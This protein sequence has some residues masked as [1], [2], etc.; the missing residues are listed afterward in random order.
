M[1]LV[2]SWRSATTGGSTTPSAARSRDQFSP[3]LQVIVFGGRHHDY[4]V[5]AGVQ[6]FQTPM[7]VRWWPAPRRC[8]Q[9]VRV[10]RNV[11]QAEVGTHDRP[12]VGDRRVGDGEL[13]RRHLHVALADGQVDVVAF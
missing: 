5:H 12:P 9:R 13:E 3:A 2:V 6:R 7:S 8:D 1:I 10:V 11:R 4:L